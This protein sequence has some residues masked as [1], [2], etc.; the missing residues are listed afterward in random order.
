MLLIMSTIKYELPLVS[1]HDTRL[2]TVTLTIP[3]AVS[4]FVKNYSKSY[5]TLNI[6]VLAHSAPLHF[7]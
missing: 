2:Q 5:N 1:L 7:V 4:E 3:L 6:F